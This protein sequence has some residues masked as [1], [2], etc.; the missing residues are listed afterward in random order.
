MFGMKCTRVA[1]GALRRNHPKPLTQVRHEGL[2]FRY[3]ASEREQVAHLQW[4]LMKNAM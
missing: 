2:V 1:L 3:F 4:R